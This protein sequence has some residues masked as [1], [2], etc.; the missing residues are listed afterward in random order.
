MRMNLASNVDNAGLSGFRPA[1]LR[2]YKLE[3]ASTAGQSIETFRSTHPEYRV[4]NVVRNGEVLG[5]DPKLV[6]QKGDVIALGGK[7]ESLTEKMGL[8][9]PEVADQKALN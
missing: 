7:I 5:A 1:G 3:N 4:V 2:A 9:G 6:M 8:I